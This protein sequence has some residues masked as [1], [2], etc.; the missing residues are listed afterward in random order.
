MITSFLDKH[1]SILLFT[2]V[3]VFKGGLD[4][5]FLLY[6]NT[7]FYEKGFQVD[8]S[9][10]NYVFAWI[11]LILMFFWM[12]KQTEKASDALVQFLFLMVYVPFTSYFGMTQNSLEWFFLFTLFWVVVGALLR[13]KIPL[14]KV[15]KPFDLSENNV[16]LGVAGMAVLVFVLLL[17]YV[18]VSFNFDLMNVYD[19]R[20]QNPTQAVPMS[21]YLVTWTAK[22]F[23]PF[24]LVYGLSKWNR[25]T[26]FYVVPTLFLMFLLFSITGH[27]SYLFIA[28]LVFLFFVFIKLKQLYLGLALTLAGICFLGLAVYYLTN[29]DMLLTLF[30]RRTLFVPAEISFYYHEFFN[31]NPI[32]LS[33]SFLRFFSTYP[34]ELQPP[35]LI[36]EHFK[37]KP[38]MSYNNGVISDGFMHFGRIGIVVWAAIVTF[39]LKLLDVLLAG[40]NKVLLW[41]LVLVGFNSFIDGALFT[42]LLTH[43]FLIVLLIC[44]L[45]PKKRVIL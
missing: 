24:M 39:L 42:N 7:E 28:P 26:V 21:G 4:L 29:N 11:G 44:Y 15:P 16:F 20:A 38:E 13:L 34:Y 3:L 19:I 8:F 32:Y 2:A 12:P 33:N 17:Y 45:F 37:G 43:G 10:M 31:G 25:T 36:A 41:T 30:V 9:L 6:L 5:V 18:D 14:K 27:K 35:F 22:V 40:K 1:L 23:L